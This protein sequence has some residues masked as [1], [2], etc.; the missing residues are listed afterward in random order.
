M[1]LYLQRRSP[2]SNGGGGTEERLA[3]DGTWTIRRQAVRLPK[4]ADKSEESARS[5]DI[6]EQ[7][8]V[9]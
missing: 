7:V 9:P 3:N 6:D 8:H 2:T 1:L 4:P 5:C